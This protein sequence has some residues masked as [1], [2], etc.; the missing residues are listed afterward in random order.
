MAKE[1][2]LSP[3]NNLNDVQDPEEIIIREK[4]KAEDYSE[5]APEV[6]VLKKKAINNASIPVEQFD[7]A[8]FE[9]ENVYDT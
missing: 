2:E 4:E 3:K 1:K 9:K 5:E 7:W 6:D 8:A